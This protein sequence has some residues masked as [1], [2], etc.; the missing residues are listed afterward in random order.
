MTP[1][2]R[3]N[4][5][6]ISPSRKARIA[7]GAGRDLNELN[8]FLKQFEQMKDMMK[9]FNKMPGGRMPGMGFPGRRN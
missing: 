2:E 3:R 9:M 6:I 4:P 5:Q 1:E 8:Q 7:R